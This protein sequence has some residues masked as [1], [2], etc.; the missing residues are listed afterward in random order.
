MDDIP[1]APSRG[2]PELPAQ[3]RRFS[4]FA[5][6]GACP[7]P[8]Q[9]GAGGTPSA[10]NN[11]VTAHRTQVHGTNHRREISDGIS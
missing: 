6:I 11:D 8:K 7:M 5:N 2:A 9:D 10:L 4:H 1:V 3:E